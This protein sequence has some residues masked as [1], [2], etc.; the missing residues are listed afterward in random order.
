MTPIAQGGM[1]EIWLARQSGLKGF[2]RLV[3]IKRMI[4]ALESDPEHVEMFLTEAR[5]AAQLNHPH[6]VQI[7]D[8]GE[9]ANSLYLVMEYLDGENLSVVRRMGVKH[10]LPLLD[11]FAA[12]MIAWAADGL[13]Y[14]HT[15]VGVDG[16]PIGIVHRDISPQN[17]FATFDGGIKVLDFGV[18]KLASQQTSSGKLKGKLGYMSPE[19]AR[20]EQIDARSDVFALGIVLF[21]L[22][23][24]SRLFPGIEDT[25]VLGAIAH[26]TMP[27]PSE[28]RPDVDPAME[29][30]ILKAMA[31]RKEER[32]QSAREL[33]D[34]L[35]GWLAKGGFVVT[36]SDVADYLRA[37]FARRIH[38][39]RQMIEAAMRAEMTPNGVANVQRLARTATTSAITS[40]S[41]AEAQRASGKRSLAPI[42]IGGLLGAIVIAGVTIGVLSSRERTPEVVMK[43]V[44][45]VAEV[46]APL[47]PP[48]LVVSSSPPGATI[49]VDGASVGTAPVTLDSLSPGEHK[50][51]ATLE[52]FLPAT[53]MVP[54][55][56]PGERFNLELALA[57]VPV[58][59]PVVVEKPVDKPQPAKPKAMGKLTL[60]TTPWTSVFLG[61]RKLGDTPLID[62]PLPVG[63][64]VLKLKNPDTGLD[65]SI[66]VEI[67]AGQVTTKK[68]RL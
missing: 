40:K 25:Q 15:R 10:Q 64:H 20:G 3:V 50:L 66:E 35:E 56:K 42:V 58:A 23:T 52:G 43:A 60:K 6:V 16:R 22:I 33:Q 8:L 48:V 13:H 36:T 46:K 27:R 19:Q 47:A 7:F 67:K 14:A 61:A 59:P 53:R 28:R 5:L 24:R 34:A 9:D 29:Q 57:P 51:E 30:I 68:L 41:K 21:E 26:G 4:D 49:S 63:T 62:E 54:L 39:R 65:S 32:Y 17:L 18:A 45:T 38:D 12:R 44:P 37:L 1:A 2:E 31:G 11:H 55:P